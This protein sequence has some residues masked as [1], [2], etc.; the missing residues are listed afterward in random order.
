M[1]VAELKEILD[2]CDPDA[3]VR[4]ETGQVI[5]DLRDSQVFHVQKWGDPSKWELI[6]D[7]TH[8]ENN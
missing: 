4:I 8:E 2:A 1:T 7:V 3:E 5:Y 6:L